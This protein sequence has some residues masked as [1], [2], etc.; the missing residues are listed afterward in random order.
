MSTNPITAPA[1]TQPPLAA[2]SPSTSKPNV[3]DA[4]SNTD[5]FLQLLVAQLK[6]QDPLNPAD[7]TAFVTQLATFSGVEQSTQMR[8][9]L[10]AM[11]TALDKLATAAVPPPATTSS[12]TKS[13]TSTTNS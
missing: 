3:A 8:N 7:G 13:S 1:V 10:D 4:L 9:D 6:N 11:K 5:T 2:N 12:A